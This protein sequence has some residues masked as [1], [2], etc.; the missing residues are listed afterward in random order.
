LTQKA[1]RKGEK[2]NRKEALHSRS[3]IFI[4]C[5]VAYFFPSRSYCCCRCYTPL[6]IIVV[7]D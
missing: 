5:L 7:L 3:Q 4:Y 6:I 1:K 2:R